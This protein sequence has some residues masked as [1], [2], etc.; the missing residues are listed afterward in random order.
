M[1]FT[2]FNLVLLNVISTTVPWNFPTSIKSPISKGLSVIIVNPP[3]RLFTKSCAAKATTALPN[4]K[5]VA[6]PPKS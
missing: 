3:I 2:A 4:P 6:N 5:P 1:L